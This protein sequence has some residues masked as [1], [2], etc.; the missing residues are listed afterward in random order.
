CRSEWAKQTNSKGDCRGRRCISFWALTPAPNVCYPAR[1]MTEEP[2]AVRDY[3]ITPHAT[4]Q[5]TRRGLSLAAIQTVLA[6]PEQRIEVRPGR[7]VL[8]SRIADAAGRPFLL[9]VFVDVRRR[10][11]EVVTTYRTRRIAKYWRDQA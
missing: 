10:P 3:V 5:I 9:R 8:Q 4:R 7:V 2:E 11:A 6:A 1:A